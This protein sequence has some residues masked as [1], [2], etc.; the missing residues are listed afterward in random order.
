MTNRS[1]VLHAATTLTVEDRPV[2]VPLPGHVLVKVGAVGI[3]GSDVHYYEH[4][5]IGGYSPIL[6]ASGT[7][8]YP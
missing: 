3:C 4:G 2:P 5:R 7:A 8:G 6:A 1:A